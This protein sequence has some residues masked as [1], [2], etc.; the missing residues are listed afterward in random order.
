MTCQATILTEFSTDNALAG[1]WLQMRSKLWP[2]AAEKDH[3]RDV[4]MMAN[5]E[6]LVVLALDPQR[7]CVGFAEVS[8]RPWANGC[9]SSP[10]AY[11]EGVYV[12]PAHRGKQAADVMLDAAQDWAIGRGMTEFASDAVIENERSAAAHAKWGFDEVMRVVC[13][14]KTLNAAS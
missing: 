7:A 8:S 6:N 3:E 14:R 4:E 1:M 2:H 11:L 12:E 13:F 5:A 10:V 9:E